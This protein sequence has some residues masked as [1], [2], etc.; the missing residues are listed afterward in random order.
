MKLKFLIFALTI[1]ITD[2]LYSQEE[3]KDKSEFKEKFEAAN[4][5]MDDNFHEFAKEIWLELVK[6]NPE[7]ANINY[8][9]GY[10][11]LKS[12]NNKK[13][14]FSYLN[15]AKNNVNERYFPLD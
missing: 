9:T 5:L 7:N 6:E 15:F 4:S 8:K 11:L 12:A 13:D 14:A 10:C 2:S 1:L 3:S